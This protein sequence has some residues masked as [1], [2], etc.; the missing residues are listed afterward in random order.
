MAVPIRT[1][2]SNTTFPGKQPEVSGRAVDL[3]IDLGG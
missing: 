2:K 1:D 3:L